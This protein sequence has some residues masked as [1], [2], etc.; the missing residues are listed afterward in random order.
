M[1]AARYTVHG[2]PAAVLAPVDTADPEPGP[3]EV[4]VAVLA[5]PVNPSDLL[6]IEGRYGALPDLPAIGGSEGVGRIIEGPDAGALVLLPPGPGMWQE[7]RALPRDGLL[8]LP[9]G[10]PQ[11]LAMLAVNPATAALIL[12]LAGLSPGDWVIQNAATSAFA[13]YARQLARARGLRMVDVSRRDAD[14]PDIDGADIVLV[15][16]PALPKRLA[17]A[18]AGS[19]IR[20]GLDGIAGDATRRLANCLGPGGLLVNYGAASGEPSAISSRAL[21]FN[22]VTLRGF[23]LQKTLKAMDQAAR[24]DLFSSLAELV[25]AGTLRAPVAATYSLADV[26]EAVAHAACQRRG[27]KVLVLPN[28]N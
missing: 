24:V 17:A 19:N 10:D 16:G 20:L 27:G 1:R 23:W 3:G 4:R 18:T 9:G 14:A 21:I 2:D 6:T 28:S 5:S 13:A 25:A 8:P 12:D 22:E 11:Q 26:A 7:V 15:D